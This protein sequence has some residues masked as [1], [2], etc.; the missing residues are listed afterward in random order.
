MTQT[1]STVQIL[2]SSNSIDFERRTSI[3]AQFR[4]L[5]TSISLIV[6]GVLLVLGSLILVCVLPHFGM[7]TP[8]LGLLVT[9]AL[10]GLILIALGTYELHTSY[11]T[12]EPR[13]VKRIDTCKENKP[14]FEEAPFPKPR[15]KSVDLI[16]ISSQPGMSLSIRTGS[17]GKL[18]DNLENMAVKP[19]P[20]ITSEEEITSSLEKPLISP[21]SSRLPLRRVSDDFYRKVVLYR[22]MSPSI[23]EKVLLFEPDYPKKND[24]H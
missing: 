17:E 6:I 11:M 7:L 1:S 23:Y 20:L 14:E 22:K 21:R 24:S 2:S 5:C 16:K 9:P 4:K 15:S 12:L 10:I 8:A 19:L 18:A 13:Y 3:S